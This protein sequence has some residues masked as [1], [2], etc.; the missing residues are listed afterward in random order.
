MGGSLFL[1]WRRRAVLRLESAEGVRWADAD[2]KLVDFGVYRSG[3]RE[4]SL[5]RR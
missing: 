5:A 3:S 4:V 2:G 1:R